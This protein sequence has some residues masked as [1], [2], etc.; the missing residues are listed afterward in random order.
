MSVGELVHAPII[1]APKGEG[2]NFLARA[3]N[4]SNA[5]KSQDEERARMVNGFPPHA[6]DFSL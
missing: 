4:A 1:R 3:E 6:K 2:D 5:R